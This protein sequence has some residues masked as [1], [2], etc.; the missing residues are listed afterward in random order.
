MGKVPKFGWAASP[1]LF[2]VRVKGG[3]LRFE[4]GDDDNNPPK[5]LLVRHLIS[6]PQKVFNSSIDLGTLGAHAASLFGRL[7]W[8]L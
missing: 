5:C 7:L 3:L 4:T 8:R 1:A 6:Q 2:L